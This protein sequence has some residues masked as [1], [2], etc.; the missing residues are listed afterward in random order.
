MPDISYLSYASDENLL[1]SG[2]SSATFGGHR[3]SHHNRNRAAQLPHTYT[4]LARA[5]VVKRR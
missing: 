2:A 5:W 1:D 3:D 4:Y